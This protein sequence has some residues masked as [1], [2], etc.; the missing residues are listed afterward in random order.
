VDSC[1]RVESVHSRT[2]EPRRSRAARF[3]LFLFKEE[4]VKRSLSFLV[5]GILI[6][7]AAHAST[8]DGQT[9]SEE[10]VC[11]AQTGAAYGL[12]TAYCEAMDCDSPSPHASATACS[13]VQQNFLRITG[14]PLPCDVPCPCAG[15]LPVFAAIV[16]GGAM[17][18][19]CVSDS[20]T[21]S[22]VL[23]DGTFA[24]VNSAASPAFC[25]DNLQTFVNL[26]A[27]EA[28][29]C[30]DLLRRAVQASGVACVAP[31]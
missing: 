13:R 5:L 31:E 7:P 2:R 6:V 22:A 12:C 23:A 18:E 8:P 9:P 1:S 10:T 3:H 17:A 11:D 29:V 14:Q 21:G 16:G 28:I 4:N 26:T 24:V 27:A 20:S 15:Q 19:Q 30:R 25:S